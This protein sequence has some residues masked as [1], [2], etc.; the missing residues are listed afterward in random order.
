MV[1]DLAGQVVFVVAAPL[2]ELF[3]GAVSGF[4]G[5]LAG[6]LPEGLFASLIVDGIIAGVGA[7]VVF[8][9]QIAL[10][11]LMIALQYAYQNT[12][13]DEPF[14]DQELANSP[15]HT[16]S[17]KGTAPIYDRYLRLASRI[18]VDSTR[19]QLNGEKVDPSVIWDLVFSGE[20]KSLSI[21]Y[22]LGVRN[23]L[24]WRQLVPAGKDTLTSVRRRPG[25]TVFADITFIY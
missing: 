20:A 9:P 8:V 1:A 22:A 25:R 6:V 2:Q 16:G 19:L 12:R 21:R 4:G 24:D 7:V 14:G 3:E 11:L 15:A 10:L 13:V 23:L 17:L 18:S 5:W